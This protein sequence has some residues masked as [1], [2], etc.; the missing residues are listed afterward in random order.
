M[1][2]PTIAQALP[3]VNWIVLVSLGVGAF[4]YAAV[5]REVTDATRGYLGFT[6]VSGALLAGLA[7]A[8]DFALPQ[9]TALVINEAPPV[10][11]GVRQAGLAVFAVLALVYTIALRRRSR[12]TLPLAVLSLAGAIAAF[13]AAAIGW[14][15]TLPDSIPLLVQLTVLSAAAGGALAALALGHWYLVT[16]RLSERPLILLTRILSAVIAVQLALFVVWTTV[17]GGPGQEPFRSFTTG[18]ALFVWLR[19]IVGLAFPLVLAW[20]A[21]RTAMTR[22][23]E[24]ATGLLYLALA[25][26]VSGTIAA[27][28]VYVG[29]GFLV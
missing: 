10:L 25:A 7:L 8:S 2:L 13:L 17:A 3:Y 26:V 4:A 28:A 18:P 9:P 5:A 24:S 19:L 27:A 11:N 16:P 12:R 29:S 1:P 14:A 21:L 22:S 23:M 15:P 20:M 6:A